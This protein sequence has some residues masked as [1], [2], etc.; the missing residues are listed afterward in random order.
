[1]AVT[2]EAERQYFLGVAGI[3]M[4]YPRQPLSGAAASVALDFSEPPAEPD[5]QAAVPADMPVSVAP[6]TPER[7]RR[8]G[9]GREK[10][11]GVRQMVAEAPARPERSAEPAETVT[12]EPELPSAVTG[13]EP[14]Q[15]PQEH[16]RLALG[17]W[18][19]QR[20]VLLSGL[21]AEASQSLQDQLARNIL[22]ALG[23]PEAATSEVRWPV[24][25]HPGVPGNDSDGLAKVLAPLRERWHGKSVVALGV[26]PERADMEDWVASAFRPLLVDYPFGLA[27]L[28]AD[29]S[30]KKALWQQLQ[31]VL[32]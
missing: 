13:P 22:L 3:R 26:L 2:N 28:G 7:S 27:G 20:F 12:E 18:E 9:L 30:R 31:K 14:D 16:V 24:F 4:W 19:C 15:A 21:S 17:I 32:R 8:S 6:V 11:S 1:M 25:S 23:E 10:L 5:E 29:A